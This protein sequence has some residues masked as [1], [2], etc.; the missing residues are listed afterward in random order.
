MDELC[1]LERA[2][3][4]G[5][6]ESEKVMIIFVVFRFLLLSGSIYFSFLRFRTI[7]KY[8]VLTHWS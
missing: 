5:I 4:F 2:T 8:F 7:S 6:E 3:S 1:A